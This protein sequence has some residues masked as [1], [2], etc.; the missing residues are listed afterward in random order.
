VC[1]RPVSSPAGQGALVADVYQK[2]VVGASPK[3]A[4]DAAVLFENAQSPGDPQVQA[5]LKRL[6][7]TRPLA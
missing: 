7:N 1:A 3:A 4:Q 6:S 2:W 5:I